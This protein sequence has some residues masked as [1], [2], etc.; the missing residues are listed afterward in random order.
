MDDPVY[1]RSPSAL[2]PDASLFRN[3]FF[4][5]PIEYLLAI[6]SLQARLSR[7]AAHEIP[8]FSKVL[9]FRAIPTMV[10]VAA[11]NDGQV[12]NSNPSLPILSS[13]GRN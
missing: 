6:E 10:M 13:L 5:C 7:D 3:V 1:S 12:A 8:V 2:F 11:S 4:C 9:C